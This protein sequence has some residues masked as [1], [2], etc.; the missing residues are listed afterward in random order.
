MV[1][2]GL[3]HGVVSIRVVPVEAGGLEDRAQIGGQDFYSD[4]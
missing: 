4:I 3:F 1:D 2:D